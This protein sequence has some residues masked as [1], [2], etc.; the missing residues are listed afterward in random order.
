ME[1]KGIEWVCPNCS[2]KKEEE[3]KTKTNAH[4][5]IG[6]Q[7]IQSGVATDNSIALKNLGSPNQISVVGETSTSIPS[8]S[9]YNDVQ[10]SS[11][12]QCV[13]CKKE[14]RNSSIYCSDACILA[15]AQETLTKDKP[16]STG[17]TATP[18]GTRTLPLDISTKSKPESRVI[19]FERK[20]GKVLSGK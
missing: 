3:L 7:R 5:I 15:H 14:A 18:K 2:K 8:N 9:D 10:Y 12:M 1:E 19:V 6:K 16:L 13:V 11:G 4:S 17:S 20:T